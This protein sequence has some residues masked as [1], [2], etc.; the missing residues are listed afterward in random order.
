MARLVHD[1]DR[2]DEE[3]S[4]LEELDVVG[5]LLAVAEVVLHE[6][7][8]VVADELTDSGV[9]I[10]HLNDVHGAL[11]GDVVEEKH[12]ATWYGTIYKELSAHANPI[13]FD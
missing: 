13:A 10:G 2:G 1:D 12:L 3:H 7:L 6:A 8:V 11:L 9:L 5:T 4:V